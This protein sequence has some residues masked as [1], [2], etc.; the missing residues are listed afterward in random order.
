MEAHMN[1]WRKMLTPISAAVLWS[2]SQSCS[3]GFD[4][5]KYTA[6]KGN[7]GSGQG[8]TWASKHSA[9]IDAADTTPAQARLTLVMARTTERPDESGRGRHECL[10]YLRQLRG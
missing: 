4:L 2:R 9:R 10:R 5:R 1:Q 7:A 8:F 6:P 3:G